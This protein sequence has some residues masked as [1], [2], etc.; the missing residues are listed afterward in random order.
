MEGDWLRI[1]PARLDTPADADAVVALL[2]AYASDPMGGGAPLPEGAKARL[3]DA[4]RAV[5]H[6]LVLLAFDGGRA[7]GIAVCFQGF[8][9]FRARPLL[10]VHDLAVLASHRGRGVGRALLSAV[11]A[12]ARSRG[13]CKLTLEVR[14]DNPVAA[15]L[16][17][18]LGFGPGGA[19]DAP[20]P[21][22]F[23]EKRLTD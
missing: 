15:G 17:Q 2:D 7:V 8:S 23:L 6:H 13:C 19:E 14:E 12:E 22:R 1:R 9:T 10:N 4:L 18:G 11:E 5:P 3:V 16:Y 20:V 21:H